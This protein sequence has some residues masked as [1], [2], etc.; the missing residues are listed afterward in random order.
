MEKIESDGTSPYI[1]LSLG[2]RK[3]QAS[4]PS[5][6]SNRYSYIVNKV[7]KITTPA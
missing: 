4:L 2:M 7:E 6:A 5:K 1:Y 3:M